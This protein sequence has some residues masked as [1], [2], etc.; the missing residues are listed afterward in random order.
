MKIR[1]TYRLNPDLDSPCVAETI[2]KGISIIRVGKSY[3]EAK[4]LVISAVKEAIKKDATIPEP[5]EVELEDF[6]KERI[7]T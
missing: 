2:Y 6:L 5:E 1:I 7:E 4:E 3:G